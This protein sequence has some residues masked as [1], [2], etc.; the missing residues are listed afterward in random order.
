[1]YAL[2]EYNGNRLYNIEKSYICYYIA[3]TLY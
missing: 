2:N 3:D 1:M